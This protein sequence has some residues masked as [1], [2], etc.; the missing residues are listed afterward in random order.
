MGLTYRKRIK[1]APGVNL[2]VSKKGISSVSIGKRGASL[3]INKHGSQATFGVPGSGLSYKTKRT[4]KAKKS[5][6]TTKISSAN[7]VMIGQN[8]VTVEQIINNKVHALAMMDAINYQYEND[9]TKKFVLPSKKKQQQ[10]LLESTIYQMQ[11]SKLTNR[12]ISLSVEQ[13]LREFSLIRFAKQE[14]L[15][16]DDLS[17]Y[18]AA[19]IIYI[20]SYNQITKKMRK[21]YLEDTIVELASEDHLL[22]LN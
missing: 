18:Q 16:V 11:N 10:E 22:L 3:N 2:N 4:S 15:D 12:Q 20:A 9:L 6:E 7:N 14:N 8:Q 17:N 5:A 19:L 21:E 1:I 13:A